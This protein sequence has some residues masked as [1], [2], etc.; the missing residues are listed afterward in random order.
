MLTKS[1]QG[2]RN[3]IPIM[4]FILWFVGFFLLN[5]GD[6]DLNIQLIS[7]VLVTA[8]VISMCLV[9][10][11]FPYFTKN[12]YFTFLFALGFLLMGCCLE[13]VNFF[14]GLFFLH[15]ILA[16]ILYKGQ[17]ESYIFNSFD[18]GFYVGLAI[19]FYPPFWI[20]GVFLLLHFI[21]LGKTQIVNLIFSLLGTIAL[22]VLCLEL[23]A[24]FDAWYYWEIFVNQLY[25]TPIQL[26]L[27]HLFLIPLILIAILGLVDYYSNINRQSSNKKVVFFDALLW[28]VF[29]LIYLALYNEGNDNGLLLL[30]LPVVLFSSNFLSYSKIFWHKEVVLWIF[31]IS[32]LLYRFHTHIK[33]PDLFDSVTF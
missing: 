21:V 13:K 17:K 23:M 31:V 8:T 2:N 16:Q 15:L 33:V 28:F 1:L 11:Y 7:L 20:F 22:F 26:K 3:F 30:V 6:F 12:F 29:A 4:I 19:I 5:V 10:D 24:I 18:L 27:S 14:A 25:F 32:L 9:V